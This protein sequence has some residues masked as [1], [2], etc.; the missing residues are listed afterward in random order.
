MIELSGKVNKGI[1]DFWTILSKDQSLVALRGMN[2]K[3]QIIEVEGV[4]QQ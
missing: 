4:K 3:I 2:V 1:R